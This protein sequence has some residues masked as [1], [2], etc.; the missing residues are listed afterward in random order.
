[1]GVNDPAE[2]RRIAEVAAAELLPERWQVTVDLDARPEET[3]LWREGEWAHIV[4]PLA[5]KGREGPERILGALHARR[6]APRVGSVRVSVTHQ[7]PAL[8]ALALALSTAL[9]HAE[10][11]RQLEHLSLSDPLTGLGNRRAF[12]EAL[13]AELSRARRTGTPLGLVML[14]VDHFKRFNDRHG[15]QA[16]DDALVSVARVLNEVA[17]AEDRACRIGGEEFAVLL[18]GGDEAAAHALAERIRAGV[19]AA[20]AAERVTVSLGVA[21]TSGE[22][23]ADALVAAADARLYEAKRAGRNRVA[24]G[25]ASAP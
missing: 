14:D 17:R 21:A 24:G 7:L 25:V 2:L 6:H 20:E 3:R 18:P 13:A 22:H 5:L 8:D 12:D 19:A 4:I 23:D 16:G 15:H 9:S 10:L 11:V 1:V